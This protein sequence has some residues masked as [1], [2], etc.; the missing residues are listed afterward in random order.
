MLVK[1]YARIRS[2]DHRHVCIV[3]LP[4]PPMAILELPNCLRCLPTLFNQIEKYI[5]K[6]ILLTNN[7]SFEQLGKS[8]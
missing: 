1:V 3:F 2:F 5:V 8:V 7:Y 6:V 4:N